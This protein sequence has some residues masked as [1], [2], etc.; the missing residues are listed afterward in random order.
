MRVLAAG[1]ARDALDLLDRDPHPAVLGEVQLQ[2]VAL[3]V[4]VA[5]RRSSGHAVVAADAVVDVDD[6]VARLEPLQQILWYDPAEHPR[7]AYA[8]GAE[9]LAIRDEDDAVRT[10]GEARIQAAVDQRQPAG[11][12]RIGE[13]AVG[14]ATMSASPRISDSRAD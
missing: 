5:A 6:Q 2:E 3:L 4:A 10:A 9:E 8:D 14:A 11:R 13:P 12:R 7:P 1:V